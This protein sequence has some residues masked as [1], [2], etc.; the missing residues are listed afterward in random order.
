MTVI[1]A[2]A[3]VSVTST[4][5]RGNNTLEYNTHSTSTDLLRLDEPRL[6]LTARFMG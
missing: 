3:W 1:A 2:Y 5:L 4:G 6:M